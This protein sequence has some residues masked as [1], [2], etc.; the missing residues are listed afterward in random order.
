MSYSR[1][2]IHYV[3]STKF[4]RHTLQQPQRQLL[5]DHIRQN[6][7]VKGIHLDR[8]NGY[9]DHVHCLVWLQ[10]EQSVSEVAQLIKGESAHW[11]NH[12]PD[13]GKHKLQWQTDYF[14]ASVSLS[15]V[16]MVRRYIDNQERHHQKKTFVTEYEEMLKQFL[17]TKNL[18]NSLEHYNLKN[19]P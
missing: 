3:W 5:F 15:M 9:T 18:D 10:P 12:S 11:F 14:A 2:F 6:T 13:M 17:I 1:V 4:R 8:I 7:L 16:D 19:I